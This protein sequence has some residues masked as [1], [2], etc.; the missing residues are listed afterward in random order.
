MSGAHSALQDQISL[1]PAAAAGPTKGRAASVPMS[2]G[3][4]ML[5]RTGAAVAALCM[6]V[7]SCGTAR[8]QD[9]AR[10]IIGD[11][12]VVSIETKEVAS[13]KVTRPLGDRLTG[14]FIFTPGGRFSGMV[15][16][17]DRKA[18]EGADATEA[19]RVALFNS[20]VAY[21]GSYRTDGDKLVMT[22]ESSHI[23]SWNGANRVLTIEIDG[24]RLTGRSAPLKAASTGLEVIAENVW[25]RLE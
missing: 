16:R 8:A 2:W 17:A 21:N 15:F 22:I 3:I 24:A 4:V 5:T 11:W 9:L 14:T 1:S 12:R 13:G 23:Q 20:L 25:E 6:I 19:E 7:I 18:P 10:A